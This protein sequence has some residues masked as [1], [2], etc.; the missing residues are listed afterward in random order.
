[1][2]IARK[3]KTGLEGHRKQSK[4]KSSP[5][6]GGGSKSFPPILGSSEGN[7]GEYKLWSVVG[8][9]LSKL[10]PSPLLK[11]EGIWWRWSAT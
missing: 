5:G 10:S 1:M 9:T 4:G 7:L 8:R 2:C 6:G 11:R 3:W